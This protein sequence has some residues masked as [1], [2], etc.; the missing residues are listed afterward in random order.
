MDKEWAFLSPLTRE[1]EIQATLR[2]RQSRSPTPLRSWYRA[3]YL[4]LPIPLLREVQGSGEVSY[5]S[6]ILDLRYSWLLT[7]S[8]GQRHPPC[9]CRSHSFRTELAITNCDHL[10]SSVSLFTPLRMQ[11]PLLT[12]E[13]LGLS[14]LV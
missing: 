14:P 1:K 4:C 2:W 3:S 5:R 8:S 13:A 7:T 6:L 10:R 11:R 9:D 12:R